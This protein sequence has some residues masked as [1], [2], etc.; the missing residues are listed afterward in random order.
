MEWEVLLSHLA[1]ANICTVHFFFN[2]CKHFCIILQRYSATKGGRCV[3]MATTS[4]AP[5]A[6]FLNVSLRKCS[7]GKKE[8]T[9]RGGA[10]P[11]APSDPSVSHRRADEPTGSE[12]PDSSQKISRRSARASSSSTWGHF[13][14]ARIPFVWRQTRR[15]HDGRERDKGEDVLSGRTRNVLK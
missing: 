12:R 5:A 1:K 13:T 8:E 2:C 10:D 6:K 15:E 7:S 4:T 11:W 14:L 9:A 3:V